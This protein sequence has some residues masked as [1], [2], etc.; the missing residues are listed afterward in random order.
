MSALQMVGTETFSVACG[1]GGFGG[2]DK[3]RT[4]VALVL[5]DGLEISMGA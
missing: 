2:L 3:P 1:L 5:L 4:V